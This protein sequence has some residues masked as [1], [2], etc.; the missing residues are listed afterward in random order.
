MRNSPT[1]R[2]KERTPIHPVEIARAIRAKTRA[3]L[4][5]REVQRS[6]DSMV[7]SKCRAKKSVN[8]L[9]S[10]T[11]NPRSRKTRIPGRNLKDQVVEIR[12]G[13]EEALVINHMQAHKA[14]EDQDVGEDSVQIEV[15]FKELVADPK[16]P[17]RWQFIPTSTGLFLVKAQY[18]INTCLTYSLKNFGRLKKFIK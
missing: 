9:L 4:A 7:V 2:W 14:R 10:N 18:S 6:R 13:I 12:E 15:D 8:K 16:E 17:T 5:S 3:Y 1:F 11:R